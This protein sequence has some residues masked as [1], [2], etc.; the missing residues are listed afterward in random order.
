MQVAS[1]IESSTASAEVTPAVRNAENPAPRLRRTLAKQLWAPRERI[2]VSQW[3]DRYRH[4]PPEG[5][6]EPGRWSTARTPYLREPMDA[7]TDPAVSQITLMF[8]A[9]TGKTELM[10]NQIFYTIDVLGQSAMFMWPV[11][12]DTTKF[13]E[14]RLKPSVE[15]CEKI[16][17]RLVK[18]DPIT[19]KG[20]RYKGGFVD[21][22]IA[23]TARTQKG[24][25]RG[26]LFCDEIDEY[27]D[28]GA[29]GRLRNRSKT[30]GDRKMVVSSTPTD[31]NVGIHAEFLAGDRRK[32]Y[33]PCPFCKHKQ[34]LA[35]SR[36][37]WEGGIGATE[38]AV[39]HNT[40]YE[41]ENCNGRIHEHE[42]HAMLAAGEWQPE[43]T[44][45]EPT[46]HRSYQLSELYSP[47]PSS[48]WGDI[49]A[50]FVKHK[51]VPP[52]EFY[53]ER[54]G[55]PYTAKGRRIES[56]ALRVLAAPTKA[57]G[58][59]MRT[60]PLEVKA[61][62]AAIDV[63]QNRFYY[64]CRGFG[65]KGEKSWLI[66]AREVFCRESTP[67]KEIEKFI[68]AMQYTQER[69]G[70]QGGTVKVPWRPMAWAVDTGDQTRELYA[71]IMNFAPADPGR[72]KLPKVY[73]SKGQDNMTVPFVENVLDK[74]RDGTQLKYGVRLINVHGPHY[75]EAIHN[76]FKAD[77]RLGMLKN[78]EGDAIGLERSFLPADVGDEYLH[79]MT[80]EEYRQTSTK[81]RG[82]WGKWGWMK[83]PGVSRNDFWDC[84]VYVRALADQRHIGLLTETITG[85]AILKDGPIGVPGQTPAANLKKSLKPNI[86]IK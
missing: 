5:A 81:A 42:K 29:V 37:K 57:G 25:P 61:L 8:A 47:F 64:V 28:Q 39:R 12:D 79:H 30:F 3:A 54:L 83:R 31:E 52:A 75:K 14:R 84:E 67:A 35:F 10:L 60:I 74:M 49:A 55:E 73:A 32:Y 18:T 46:S 56:H 26:K 48:T 86:S 70:V 85:Y 44:D 36:V 59:L 68:H 80:S 23:K 24:M 34:V 45:A 76:E 9:Q 65:A 33:V 4:L 66:D 17:G 50:E 22:A 82:G 2:T 63:Q 16:R 11:E 77:P 20:I 43:D 15:A 6:A 62:L 40:W 53:T 41:C 7:Y 69:P 27:E 38:D 71:T 1:H 13:N 72:P 78:I 19:Q 21:Y 51:G 58:Y